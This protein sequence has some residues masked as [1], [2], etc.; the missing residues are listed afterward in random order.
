MAIALAVALDDRERIGAP[1]LARTG[2]TSVWPESAMP[3][4]P[5]GPMVAKR[6]AF[7]PSGVGTSVASTPCWRR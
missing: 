5:D 6:L 4:T 2:T 1:G 3:P 7:S